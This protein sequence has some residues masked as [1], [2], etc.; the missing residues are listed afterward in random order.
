MRKKHTKH[1]IKTWILSIAALA[2]GIVFVSPLYLIFVNS[3]SLSFNSVFS[4][5]SKKIS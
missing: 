1:V 5:S 3:V 4:S 2:V